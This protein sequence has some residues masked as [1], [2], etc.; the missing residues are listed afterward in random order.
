M[1]NRPHLVQLQLQARRHTKEPAKINDQEA[2]SNTVAH[3]HYIPATEDFQETTEE[4]E[5]QGHA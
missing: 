5:D 3:H 2:Q 1:S 4:L